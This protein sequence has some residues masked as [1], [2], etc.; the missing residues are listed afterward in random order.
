MG[1]GSTLEFIG[2]ILDMLDDPKYPKPW[3]LCDFS[4]LRS[5]CPGSG[6]AWQCLGTCIA[7]MRALLVV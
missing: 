2:L 7:L 6:G 5:R 1:P 4:R 3:E